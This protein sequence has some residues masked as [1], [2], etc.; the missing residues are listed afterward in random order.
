MAPSFAKGPRG[1]V[2]IFDPAEVQ[3]A[4]DRKAEDVAAAVNAIRRALAEYASTAREDLP[5]G[6]SQPDH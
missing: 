1:P 5:E 3:L 4:P 6:Q 2:R